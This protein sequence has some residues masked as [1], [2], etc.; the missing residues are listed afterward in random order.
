MSIGR[1]FGRMSSRIIHRLDRSSLFSRPDLSCAYCFS[2][3]ASDSTS[4]SSLSSESYPIQNVC[5]PHTKAEYLQKLLIQQPHSPPNAR[6]LKVAVFGCPN[7]GKSS[8]INMLTKW[9]V[10]AVSGK[11]HTTRSKQMAALMKDN[12][13]V[14]F[15]DLPGIVNKGKA[16]QFNLDKAFIRDPHSASFE[17][18]I[19]MVVVDVSHP[20][21]RSEL[22]PEIVKALHFFDDKESILVLNKIDLARNNPTRLLDITRRLTQGTVDGRRWHLDAYQARFNRRARLSPTSP[23]L[24]PPSELIAAYLP[25]VCHEEA[26]KMLSKLAEI[27]ARLSPPIEAVPK[28]RLLVDPE[29]RDMLAEVDEDETRDLQPSEVLNTPTETAD[30]PVTD[31]ETEV[32]DEYFKHY[33]P[34]SHSATSPRSESDFEDNS[35]NADPQDEVNDALCSTPGDEPTSLIN[36]ND[37][38]RAHQLKL[39]TRDDPYLDALLDTLKQQLLLHSAS[40][41]EVAERRKRWLEVSVAVQGVTSWP[42]FSSVFMVSSANGDGIDRL[43]DYLFQR[44]IPGRPWFM[45]P[46]LVTDQEPSEL[47]R[48]CVWA[49]CLDKLRQEIPYSLRIVVDDCEKARLDDGDDRVFVHARIQCKS[50]RH[51]RQVLGIK[52]STITELAASVK[53]EL[54]NMFRANVVIKLTAEMASIR[55]N[56]RHRIRQAK[57]FAD[58]FPEQDRAR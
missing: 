46:S 29:H 9:R 32:I 50:E 22:D 13:Q 3:R 56:V 43:R 18:D 20:R 10:C 45:S 54:M 34:E 38:L 52:G 24:Q 2:Q 49:H 47:V 21:S 36:D 5:V 7:T 4:P 42:G 8:L 41:E 39:L 28:V 57:D 11:A 31:V 26:N 23:M 27:R 15:V 25:P 51:L 16:R 48:M 53:Q 12:V 1:L 33:K 6:T 55:P 37:P 19:I 17:A 35:A 14:V 40:P 30:R 44:A 58:V